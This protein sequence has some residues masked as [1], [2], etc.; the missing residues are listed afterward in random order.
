M[1]DW[2]RLF[3]GGFLTLQ[4]IIIITT[5]SIPIL[6]FVIGIQNIACEVYIT[7][8]MKIR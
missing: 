5:I 4:E 6:R 7:G 8:T 1:K 3:P 2:S